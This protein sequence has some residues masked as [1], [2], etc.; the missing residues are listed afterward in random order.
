[1]PRYVAAAIFENE[2]TL[3][4]SE[5]YLRTG[6]MDERCFLD[7]VKIDSEV[8]EDPAVAALLEL[9]AERVRY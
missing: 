7:D 4:S 9:D 5:N 3:K 2:Q 1:M 6:Q 8:R